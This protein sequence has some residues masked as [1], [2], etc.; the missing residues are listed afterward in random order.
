MSN[1]PLTVPFDRIIELIRGLG[2][3]PV[4]PD[5][6]RRI[7]IDPQGIEVVRY[8]RSETGGVRLGF[9]E[10]PLTETVTIGFVR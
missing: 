1:D 10:N 2:I 8:R 7:T 3:D 4:D 9:A 6:I 5:D